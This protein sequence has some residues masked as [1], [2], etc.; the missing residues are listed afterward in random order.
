MAAL[1]NEIARKTNKLRRESVD[2]SHHAFEIGAITFVMDVSAMD[3]TVF[4]FAFAHPDPADFDPLRFQPFGIGHGQEG[5]RKKRSGEKTAPADSV[6][7]HKFLAH[8][9]RRSR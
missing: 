1:L 2:F 3:E 6:E 5:R 8:R 9:R 7:F 4:G